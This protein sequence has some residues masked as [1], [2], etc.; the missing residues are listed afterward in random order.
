MENCAKR[1]WLGQV[2]PAFAS[3][4]VQFFPRLPHLRFWDSQPTPSK[5][6]S[7][8]VVPANLHAPTSSGFFIL[9]CARLASFT[10]AKK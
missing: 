7:S 9:G 1:Q 2:S 4:N 8:V 3:P 5:S 6:N 10:R